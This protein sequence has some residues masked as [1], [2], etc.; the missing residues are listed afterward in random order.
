MTIELTI[1]GVVFSR[2]LSTY[3]ITQE[4][5]YDK[6]L[7]TVS[8]KEIAIGKKVRDV[9]TFSLLPLT[10]GEATSYYETLTSDNLEVVYTN[11][12]ASRAVMRLAS[13]LDAVFLL[14]SVD[15]RRRYRGGE[16]VLRSTE[17]N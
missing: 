12:G 16:I 15:G 6:I 14:D 4:V 5:T 9:L 7:T 8:G 11:V 10:E 13:N 17:V 1:N 3:R 2:K